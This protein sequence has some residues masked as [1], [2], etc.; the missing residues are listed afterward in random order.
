MFFFLL[1][2]AGHLLLFTTKGLICKHTN[3]ETMSATL[4]PAENILPNAFC[5]Q[6]SH[7]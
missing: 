3:L 7:Q 6:F 4:N 5:F 1:T 2:R